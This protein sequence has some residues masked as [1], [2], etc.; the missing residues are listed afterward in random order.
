M[1]KEAA[2][3]GTLDPEADDDRIVLDVR[4]AAL[5]K[6]TQDAAFDVLE[7]NLGNGGA[8]A[9]YDIAYSNLA[10]TQPQTIARAKKSL[11]N[12]DVKKKFSAAL[13]ITMQLRT[14]KDICD[15]K[16][17]YFAEAKRSGD[18]RTIEALAPYLQRTGCGFLSSRDC[19]PCIR[20]GDDSVDK[21]IAAIR[22]RSKK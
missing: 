10:K 5:E 7:K 20:G 11:A 12:D 2:I 13:A 8:D 14:T 4:S 15:A 17:K 9:L 21:V 6:E 19:Y 1:L 3:W 22:A 18:S 16:T